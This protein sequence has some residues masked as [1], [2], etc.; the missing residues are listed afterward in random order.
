MKKFENSNFS[1]KYKKTTFYIAHS[2]QYNEYVAFQNVKYEV[3][4]YHLKICDVIWLISHLSIRI[5]LKNK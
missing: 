2:T 5:L 3:P 1:S 4:L